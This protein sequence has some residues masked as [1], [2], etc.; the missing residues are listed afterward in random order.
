[1]WMIWTGG[2][3]FEDIRKELRENW[4]AISV[5]VILIVLIAVL[6][7]MSLK[8]QEMQPIKQHDMGAGVVCYTFNTSI[9]CVQVER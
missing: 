6:T 3:M 4:L 5:A 8:T 9:D 2:E 7:T 1:M